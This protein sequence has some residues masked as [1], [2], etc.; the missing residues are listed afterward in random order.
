MRGQLISTIKNHR[1]DIFGGDLS[2]GRINDPLLILQQNN[3]HYQPA[4]QNYQDACGIY[5]SSRINLNISSLQFDTAV[6]NRVFDVVMAGG[7]ILTDAR[8]ELTELIPLMQEVSFKTPEELSEKISY[9]SNIENEY[10]YLELKHEIHSEAKK[11]S[12]INL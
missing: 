1:V 9:Y 3:I 5:Q 12:I 11:H 8:D 6:N 4:T 10:R 2:Y 7:F